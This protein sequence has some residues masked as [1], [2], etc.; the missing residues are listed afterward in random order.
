MG[1]DISQAV[2]EVCLWLPE[3]EEVVAHGSPN[4]RVRGKT[5]AVYAV[6]SSR[7]RTH[8]VVAERARGRAGAVRQARAEAFLR[9]A[10]RRAARLARCALEQGHRLDSNC[11]AGARGLREGRAAGVVETIGETISIEPPTR[12]LSPTDID[13]MRSRRAQA[14]LKKLRA[15]CLAW[16]ETSETT[17][18]GS[19][20]AGSALARA[21]QL[22]SLRLAAHA[23]RPGGRG[24]TAKQIRPR[25]LGFARMRMA[26]SYFKREEKNLQAAG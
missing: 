23:V 3:A 15:I 11:E 26:G 8:R 22:S 9:A 10:V 19:R 6:K 14:V 25:T 13:P 2:R 5:F 20:L 17:Q 21:V 24:K 16:P 7:G 1:R 18:F 4:F 12:A